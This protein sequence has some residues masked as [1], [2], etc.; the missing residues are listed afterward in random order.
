MHPFIYLLIYLP[1]YPHIN[2]SM[3]LFIHLFIFIGNIS[4]LIWQC[5]M[6]LIHQA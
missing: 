5:Q 3:Y 4:T 6:K 1:M 2:L